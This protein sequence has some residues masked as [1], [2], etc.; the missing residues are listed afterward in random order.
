MGG[1]ILFPRVS[2]RSTTRLLPRPSLGELKVHTRCFPV[3][4]HDSK[5]LHQFVK[6]KVFFH[7][8]GEAGHDGE[9]FALKV[10]DFDVAVG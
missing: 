6:F 4:S 8:V 5:S 10:G 3:L 1:I 2:L 9:G 7:A